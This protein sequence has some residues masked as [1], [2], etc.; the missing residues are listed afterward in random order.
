MAPSMAAA[1]RAPTQHSNVLFVLFTILMFFVLDVVCLI[2][3][4][5]Q[6]L[7]DIG[8]AISHRK[9][10]FT[11]LNADPLFTNTQA[12]P[13]VWA[14]RPRK[15]RRKRGNRAGVLI[16]VRRCAN[17]PLLPTIL[18]ANV[19]SL[20]NKLCELKA[21][22]SFQR[23]TRDCCIIC[24]TETW[25]SAEI[26]DSAIE[27]TGFSVHRADRAKDLSGKT[28]GGGVCFMINKSW[29]D[30]RNVHSIKS[31]C[32]PDLEFLMLLCRPFWLPRE[33]TAVIIT[34]AYI[35]PQADTDRALKELYGIISEQETA[36]PEATF[37]VT[38]DFNKASLKSV[39][40]KYHQHISFNT[41]GDRVLD[42]CYSPFRD[43]YKSLPRPP[44]G[45]SDHSSILLLPAYRQ[46]LK[47]EA[48]TLRKI[49]CWSDQSD[50]TL[51]DRFDHTDWE[52]F[53]SASDDDIELYADSVMCF[54]RTCV[55]EVIPTRTV[56]IYPNQKPWINSNVRAALNVRTSAFNSGNAE[57]HKQASY[58]LRKTIKTAKRQYRS[59]IEGQFNTTNSRSMWQGINII[60]VF[61]GNKNSAMNTAASLPDELNNFYARFEGNNTALAERALTAEALEVSSISVSVAD[62]TRS[63]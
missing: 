63:F 29:C 12:E 52:M 28:R 3:Y 22:I 21:R 36:H 7:L 53:R 62:V 41:R 47:Q 19:Q 25:M 30:Q 33:F 34:A 17:R 24:L 35:P 6:T 55:D 5:R 44:F 46:K 11:F 59:K 1:L 50:S 26:P 2:V 57:E 27:P 60:T 43:G 54:I 4:D 13:F 56:R 45:K 38:R 51:Q 15:R 9:P 49:Q 8:S 40:P 20:D 14:A 37:I 42:H 61:K 18:L 32:S 48:P 10:D 23:E 39:A 16:R 58:A 31:F